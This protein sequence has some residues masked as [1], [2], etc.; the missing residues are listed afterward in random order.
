VFLSGIGHPHRH[1]RSSEKREPAVKSI[2]AGWRFILDNH[3]LLAIMAL[4]MFAVLFGGATAMLPA[5]ADRILH[6]GS[7]GLGALRA[8]PAIGA[9]IMA[10]VL[11]THPLRHIRATT[12]LAV[13]TGFG[14]SMAGFGLSSTFW[15]ASLCLILSGAFDSCSVVIRNSLMQLLTPETMRGRV[16]AVSSMFIISSN[17]IGAFESGVAARLLGLIPSIVLGGIGTL[18]VVAL[19][20]GLSPKLRRLSV[21]SAAGAKEG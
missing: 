21:D 13:V 15:L 16:S 18:I 20:A 1:Y 7:E 14:L 19:V 5:F 9:M 4:D 8:S 3:V 10:I 12:L 17:E 11:A 2:R 6:L